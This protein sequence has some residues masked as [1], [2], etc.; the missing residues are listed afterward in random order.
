M[1]DDILSLTKNC[2]GY[3]MYVRVSNC[4]RQSGIR[5]VAQLKTKTRKDL[6]SINN[7][8]N[9]CLLSLEETLSKKGI[10]LKR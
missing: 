10:K 3:G 5:S 9:K 6:L 8:G 2:K 7:F 1:R 4:L